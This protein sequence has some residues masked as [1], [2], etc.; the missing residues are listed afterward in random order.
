[1][2][3]QTKLNLTMFQYVT[4][5]RAVNFTCE[6]NEWMGLLLGDICSS[7]RGRNG[8]GRGGLEPAHQNSCTRPWALFAHLTRTLSEPW[9][10][11][12]PR[13]WAPNRSR[14][15]IIHSVSFSTPWW[16]PDLFLLLQAGEIMDIMTVDLHRM[17][18]CGLL[19]P[20]LFY[21]QLKTPPMWQILNKTSH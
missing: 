2:Y 19:N 10:A 17:L 5:M 11:Y 3:V 8:E 18:S 9:V 20:F 21:L 16:F 13:V 12:K 4:Q 7:L 6:V 14:L 15:F 1:M